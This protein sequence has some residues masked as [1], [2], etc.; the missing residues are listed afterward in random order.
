M[1]FVSYR[2]VPSR[3]WK[4]R[5]FEPV[6][7]ASKGDGSILIDQEAMNRLQRMR[8]LMGKPLI[9][10]S[11]YRDPLHNARVGGAPRSMHKYGRAFDVSCR[12]KDRE[13]LVAAAKEAGF[14][15]LGFY[16]SWLHVDT[17][18]KRTWG[19]IWVL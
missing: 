19:N 3:A 4:W 6:E 13:N 9:I 17:G 16:N 7:I 10:N 2:D 15:G 12:F 14:S 18:P 5:D 8:D 11:A 1:Y